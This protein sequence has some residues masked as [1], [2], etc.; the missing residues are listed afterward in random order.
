MSISSILK[1]RI[2]RQ[3]L[4][5]FPEIGIVPFHNVH[6]LSSPSIEEKSGRGF[7]PRIGGNDHGSQRQDVI[8]IGHP[9][10]QSVVVVHD[11]QARTHSGVAVGEGRVRNGRF[12]R[13]EINFGYVVAAL[14]AAMILMMMIVVVV[15]IQGLVEKISVLVLRVTLVPHE[16][17]IEGAQTHNSY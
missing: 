17:H 14:R 10:G 11:Q 13:I 5:R 12:E 16:D 1:G 8:V 3:V 2:G 9:F 15:D 6:P 7:R 4:Q